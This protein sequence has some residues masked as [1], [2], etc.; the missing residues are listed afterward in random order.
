MQP[1]EV[2]ALTSAPIIAEWVAR[3][4]RTD[5]VK[6]LGRVFWFPAYMVEDCVETLLKQGYVDFEWD[7][8]P[9]DKYPE[10]E[11]EEKA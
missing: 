8:Q 1:E 7:G 5:T 3:D 6:A 2:Q 9:A 10:M 4:D 11:E